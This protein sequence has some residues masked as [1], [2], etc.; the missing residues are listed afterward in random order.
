MNS[1]IPVLLPDTTATRDAPQQK[2]L[3]PKAPVK[4]PKVPNP[5][6]IEFQS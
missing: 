2:S 6:L 3:D 4:A 1:L 5:V